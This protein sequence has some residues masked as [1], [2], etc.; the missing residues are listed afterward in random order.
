LK[1]LVTGAG[2]MVGRAVSEY[3]VSCGDTVLPY[4]HQSLD[5][6]D[7]ELVTRTLLG[8]M[9]EAVVNCAAWTDVD[10]CDLDEERAFA[11]NAQGPENLAK[12]SREANAV[13]ITISTDYVFDGKKQGF[14]TQQDGTN[15]ESVY[16][17]SKLEGERR[18][19]F[20]YARTII[21]RTG[22]VFGP[23]GS[24]FL[25]TIVARAR[26]HEKFKAIGDAFGTP[27]YSKDLAVRLRELAELDIPG[28]YHVV[29]SGEGTT[30]A[31]FTRTALDLAGFSNLPVE[32]VAMDSLRRPAKRPS[33][34][35]LRCLRSPE[36]G[37][38][39]L[40]DWRR[41]LEEFVKMQ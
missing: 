23:G 11:V 20:A 5:I 31:E 7:A 37:L 36:V 6:T 33:N 24:N 19:Q 41:S 3:C 14:Y 34:S 32:E 1:V 17:A 21:V 2:G 39:S 10:G 22:F 30:F 12:A 18:A 28:I 29:N 4:D 15:P 13:F 26:R 27:T 25:S 40:P 9:P 38:K 16:A 8:E 35:R